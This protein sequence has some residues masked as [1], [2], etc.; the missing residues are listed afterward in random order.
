M[1]LDAYLLG[2]SDVLFGLRW[3]YAAAL[4]SGRFGKIQTDKTQAKK[5]LID[6][7]DNIRNEFRIFGRRSCVTFWQRRLIRSAIWTSG[8]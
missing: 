6:I 7:P 8:R 3:A 4:K 2:V 1:I 5:D